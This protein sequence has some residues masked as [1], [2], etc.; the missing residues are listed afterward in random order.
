MPQTS[1]RD[2]S[3][4]NVGIEVS[5]ARAGHAHLYPVEKRAEKLY[6]ARRV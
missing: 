6:L 4:T 5:I 3:P 1:T 2:A